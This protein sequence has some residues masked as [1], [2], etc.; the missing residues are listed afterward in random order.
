MMKYSNY[1]SIGEQFKNSVNI[2]YD[3]L[4]FE[5][6]GL[7]IPTEDICEVLSYYFNSI[8]DNSFNRST[9]LEGPYGKGKSYLVLTLL[10]LL[11]LDSKEKNVKSFL[12]KLKDVNIELFNRYLDIKESGKI[13]WYP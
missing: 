3:L 4:N 5:K 2:E 10:Q 1:I 13:K 6:L 8:M 7:Y 12:K 9:I 11:L